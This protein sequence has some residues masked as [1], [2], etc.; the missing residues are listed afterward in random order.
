MLPKRVYK[1][2]C[3]P[4]VY[5][6]EPVLLYISDAE[7]PRQIIVKSTSDAEI[8]RP[9]KNR[10]SIDVPVMASDRV[11]DVTRVEELSNLGMFLHCATNPDHIAQRHS[12]SDS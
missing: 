4:R 2:M 10:G 12:V 1:K 6:F 7:I 5:G 9:R 11:L 3:L 8:P